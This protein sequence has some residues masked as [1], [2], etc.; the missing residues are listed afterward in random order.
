MPEAIAF[1]DQMLD[2]GYLN[3]D[4][5]ERTNGEIKDIRY[6]ETSISPRRRLYPPACKPTG[7]KRSRR[8]GSVNTGSG[9]F[10]NSQTNV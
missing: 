4:I 8:P 2:A 5:Q 9:F 1:S 10:R 7:W 3:L 6:P